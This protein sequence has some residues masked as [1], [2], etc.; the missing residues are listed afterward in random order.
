M[1]RFLRNILYFIPFAAVVYIL[2][3][4][5][6][7]E[8]TPT[9]FKSS[10]R[11]RRCGGGHLFTRLNEVRHTKGTDV[12][13]IGT[14]HCYRGFDT[15]IF[16]KAGY[17]SFNLGS[18]IQTALQ[19]QVLLNRY[20]N[21]LK[22]KLVVYEVNPV[23][24]GTDGVESS[25]DVISNDS[26]NVDTFRMASKVNSIKT[27]NTLIYALYRQISG[28]GKNLKEMPVHNNDTYISGGFVETKVEYFDGKVTYEPMDYIFK[29][30]QVN[31]FNNI[32]EML[33]QRNIP[34][35]LVQTPVTRGL[36]ESKTNKPYFD[37][38]MQSKGRYYNF[39]EL[40]RL[41]DT[42]DFYDNNHMNQNGVEK[43][44]K[45]LI[46]LMKKNRFGI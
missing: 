24:F 20:L 21:R 12:L 45:A 23:A 39:N 34:Y 29:K 17:E 33:E 26:I 3:I 32:L 41:N 1:K 18:S 6:F 11:Y 14:S 42:L 10:V 43:F 22:P 44:N 4:C 36:Y 19:T 15:R 40:L 13:F 2:A 16:R 31:A 37:S 46:N 9:Y 30:K 27:Y 25:V 5:F 28:I 7:G 38:L 35:I 8:V